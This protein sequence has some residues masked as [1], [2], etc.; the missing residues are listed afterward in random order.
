MPN[1]SWPVAGDT[2]TS[3]VASARTLSVSLTRPSSSTPDQ[4]AGRD[5]APDLALLGPGADH[6]QA[7][8]ESFATQLCGTP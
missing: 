3:A 2:N 6:Q 1:D 4:P 5:V 8:V 7:A